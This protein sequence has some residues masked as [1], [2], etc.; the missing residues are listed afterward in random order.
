MGGKKERGFGE[1]EVSCTGAFHKIKTTDYKDEEERWPP[2]L[3]SRTT[4][5]VEIRDTFRQ[6][7]VDK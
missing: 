3:H 1:H 7:I 2:T 6:S 4:H 5:I